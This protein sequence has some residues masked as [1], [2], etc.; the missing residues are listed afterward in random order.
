MRL[1]H[2]QN[3]NFTYLLRH[4]KL[5]QACA[6]FRCRCIVYIYILVIK[7]WNIPSSIIIYKLY[8]ILS[9]MAYCKKKTWLSASLFK[10][11][12]QNKS[13]VQDILL[14]TPLLNATYF[15]KTFYIKEK[16]VQENTNSTKKYQFCE[17]T[18][19]CDQSEWIYY[20]GLYI[21]FIWD[22]SL[23]GQKKTYDF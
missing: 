6:L 23:L 20:L 12:I 15:T 7:A 14:S 2:K 11:I 9:N 16:Y 8:H 4:Y 22:V 3:M 19:F 10:D 18:R 5:F 21:S 17:K 13:L 1:T